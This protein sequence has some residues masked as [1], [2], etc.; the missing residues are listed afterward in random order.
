MNGHGATTSIA[1]LPVGLPLG[2][3]TVRPAGQ[4]CCIARIKTNS[5]IPTPRSAFWATLGKTLQAIRS[6]IFAVAGQRAVQ[7]AEPGASASFSLRPQLVF[8]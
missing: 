4:A 1:A 7:T 3:N 6:R 5:T 8:F 2:P